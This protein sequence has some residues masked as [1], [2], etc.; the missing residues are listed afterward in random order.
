MRMTD[1]ESVAEGGRVIY[2]L[3][4]MVWILRLLEVFSVNRKLG[5]Y[6]VMIRRMVSM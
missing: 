6:V 2:A 4:L 5:P 3:D 1:N